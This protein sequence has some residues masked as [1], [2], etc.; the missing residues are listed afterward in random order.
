[1]INLKGGN[2]KGKRLRYGLV[3]VQDTV[4]YDLK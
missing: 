4:D 2:S 3:R 1:M